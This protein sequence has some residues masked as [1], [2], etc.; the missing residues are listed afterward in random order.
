MARLMIGRIIRRLRQDKGLTQ[1]ALAI[2]LGI[3][4]SYLNLIEHDQ[5]PVPATLLIKLTQ[6]LE[7]DLDV[8]SGQK[9][10]SL[11][12]G[13]REALTDPLL[14]AEPIGDDALAAIATYPTAARAILALS[15]AWAAARHDASAMDLPSGRRI[16]LPHVEARAVFD[17]YANYFPDLEEAAEKIRYDL[18]RELLA[19]GLG[20]QQ[21]INH[22]LADRLRNKHGLIVRVGLL[23]GA[24]RSYDPQDRV[25]MLSDLL[26][27]ES[28]GFYMAFQIA[29]LEADHVVKKLIRDICPSSE[30]A[31]SILRIGLLNYTAAALLMPYTLICEA[32]V[33]LRYDVELLATRFAVSFEQAAQRLSTL[34]RPGYRGVPLFFLRIDAA[35]NITKAY[36]GA[37]FHFSQD[38]GSCPLWVA[39]TAF[40]QPGRINVQVGQ[41][42]DGATYLCFARVI[43]GS[44][45]AWR[46]SPPVHVIAMGCEIERAPEIVYSDGLDLGKATTRI[47]LSCRLCDWTDCRSRAHPPLKHRLSL[48][49]NQHSATPMISP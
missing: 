27:R 13:L 3:S 44:T 15:R 40:S 23:D 36:A 30:Q 14:G 26:K 24:L 42:P 5:R 7:V 28:R 47:G 31:G 22:A 11:T 49:V 2:R 8:L 37:G 38:G 12:I 34:Q 20:S 17:E 32:A 10:R 35:S 16:K 9:E 41:L 25:L 4:V 19:M 18:D 33:L 6:Q 21:A 45:T 1:S 39:N 48:D 46:Q 29:L 43:T